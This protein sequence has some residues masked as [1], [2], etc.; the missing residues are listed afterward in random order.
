MHNAGEED[1]EAGA[2]EVSCIFEAV[3]DVEARYSRL[4]GSV[5]DFDMT[6]GPNAC[7]CARWA[8]VRFGPLVCNLMRLRDC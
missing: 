6:Q 1:G 2:E 3:G 8:S 4:C 5:L 7:I